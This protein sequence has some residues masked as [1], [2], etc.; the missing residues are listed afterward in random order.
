MKE[1]ELIKG[2]HTFAFLAVNRRRISE[3]LFFSDKKVKSSFQTTGFS[4]YPDPMLFEVSYRRLDRH[5]RVVSRPF[6]GKTSLSYVAIL[7]P[8]VLVRPRGSNPRQIFCNPALYRLSLPVH[9]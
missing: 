4:S 9:G 2:G 7:R 1:C 5:F 8:L 6:Q 3:V